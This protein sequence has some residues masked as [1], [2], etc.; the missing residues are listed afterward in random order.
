MCAQSM[1]GVNE[2]KGGGVPRQVRGVE[3]GT[4]KDDLLEDVEDE[5][6]EIGDGIGFRPQS[7]PSAGERIVA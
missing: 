1:S 7:D 6:V 2:D 5:I 3:R 4:A